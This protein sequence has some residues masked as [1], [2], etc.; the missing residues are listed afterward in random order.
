MLFIVCQYSLISFFLKFISLNAYDN[1][2]FNI[3]TILLLSCLL[4]CCTKPYIKYQT[5]TSIWYCIWLSICVLQREIEYLKSDIEWFKS[6][7]EI[8][9]VY[10]HWDIKL[11]FTKRFMS[12][13]VARIWF[14]FNKYFIFLIKMYQNNLPCKVITGKMLNKLNHWYGLEVNY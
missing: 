4:S 6:N 14:V 10:H 13:I 3:T 12:E 2:S 9:T 7:I 5:C 11:Y 1:D 8:I